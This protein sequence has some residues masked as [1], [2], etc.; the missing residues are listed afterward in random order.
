MNEDQYRKLDVLLDRHIMGNDPIVNVYTQLPVIHTSPA[1]Y[2]TNLEAA[3]QLVQKLRGD[4][5]F[6]FG[7]TETDELGYGIPV[8]DESVWCASFY[9]KDRG[10]VQYKY[11]S[12]IPLAIGLAALKTVGV[13]VTFPIKDIWKPDGFVVE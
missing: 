6:C 4:G 11:H 3:F 1:P 13:E 8:T 9:T 5:G 12:E 7:L 2:S 10:V